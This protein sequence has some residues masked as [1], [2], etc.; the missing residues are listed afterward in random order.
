MASAAAAEVRDEVGTTADEESQHTIGDLGEGG[1][2]GRLE[3]VAATLPEEN[4]GGRGYVGKRFI[5]AAE[6]RYNA[7]V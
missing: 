1:E 3:N 6:V 7:H 4:V 2:A 5:Q